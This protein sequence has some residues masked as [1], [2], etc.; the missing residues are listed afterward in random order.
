MKVIIDRFEGDFAVVEMPNR[1]M[2]NLPK[3]LVP[4]AHEGDVID[5]SI[6][7]KETKNRSD[8]ISRMMEDLWED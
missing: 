8:K 7:K 4:D 1:K 6:D 5:I 2:V 3:V